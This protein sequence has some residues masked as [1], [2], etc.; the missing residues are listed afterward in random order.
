[1]PIAVEAVSKA[2]FAAWVERAKQ[3][4][5]RNDAPATTMVA[6]TSSNETR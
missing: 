6:R 4:F 2:A 1:M 3:E 5:A